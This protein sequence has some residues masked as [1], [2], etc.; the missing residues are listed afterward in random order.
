MPICRKLC[1]FLEPTHTLANRLPGTETKA[2]CFKLSHASAG[3]EYH[4]SGLPSVAGRHRLFA[5]DVSATAISHGYQ[6]VGT[7]AHRI[8]QGINVAAL[9]S[10]GRSTRRYLL[11]RPSSIQSRILNFV[12]SSPGCQFDHLACACSDLPWHQLFLAMDRMSRNGKLRIYFESP[13]RY[14]LRIPDSSPG[15]DLVASGP[16][17][18][19]GRHRLHCGQSLVR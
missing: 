15:T 16:E 3:T 10:E 2:Q 17:N 19:I 5:S 1:F 14:R 4:S 6:R 11:A 12:S 7:E 9:S 8:P 13:G 18:P